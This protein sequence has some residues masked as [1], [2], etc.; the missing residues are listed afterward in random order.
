MEVDGVTSV[1]H[2]GIKQYY[3]S[4]IEE[5][6]VKWNY[7]SHFLTQDKK[8]NRKEQIYNYFDNCTLFLLLFNLFISFLSMNIW[9]PACYMIYCLNAE[10]YFNWFS[11]CVIF[12]LVVTDKTQNLRRL[13]AQRNELN[14][15]GKSWQLETIHLCT[16]FQQIQPTYT[17]IC[18][19]EW[20]YIMLNYTNK[21]ESGF[22]INTCHCVLKI[23]RLG[24]INLNF[25]FSS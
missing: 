5:L 16:Y 15:K 12:Q 4:K 6:Q 25:R 8:W 13:E 1:N 21:S 11:F 22:H 17:L 10:L 18:T 23:W 3:I 14:A 24:H 2:E 9:I 20:W 7:H 19:H